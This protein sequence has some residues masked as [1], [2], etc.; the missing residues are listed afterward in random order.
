MRAVNNYESSNKTSPELPFPLSRS[1]SPSPLETTTPSSKL[2]STVHVSQD[3]FTHNYPMPNQPYRQHR[4]KL[5]PPIAETHQIS[6]YT[7]PFRSSPSCCAA[8]MEKMR[9]E[10]F[11]WLSHQQREIQSL[12]A[13]VT[14]LNRELSLLRNPLKTEKK[15]SAERKISL[16][17][18]TEY[19][20]LEKFAGK[21]VFFR[22]N[23]SFLV[24]QQGRK[25]LSKDLYV[26]QVIQRKNTFH[27]I[28][29]HPSQ[30][31]KNK[32]TRIPKQLQ[33]SLQIGKLT[34]EEYSLK[35]IKKR[36]LS[37]NSDFIYL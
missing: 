1:R 18:I 36:G 9:V 33:G 10:M 4:Q 11:Q 32:K 28:H 19:S 34:E 35:N 20:Q 29:F 8:Q 31:S 13:Q 3:H 6:T 16:E 21:K 25:H 30:P 26:G 12:Q 2:F 17:A 27:L 24:L 15:H 7:Q 37:K 5:H 22:T 23:M 14:E